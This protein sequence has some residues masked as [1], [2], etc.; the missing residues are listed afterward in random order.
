MTDSAI[1]DP[2]KRGRGRPAGTSYVR[3]DQPLLDE[4]RILIQPGTTVASLREA[5][6][7]VAPRAHNYGYVSLYAISRRLEAYARADF[8][9]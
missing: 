3:Y 7:I 5:A 6:R 1:T 9:T 2:I 4:M 8:S